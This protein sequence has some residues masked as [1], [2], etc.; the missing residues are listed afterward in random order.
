[1]LLR[2]KTFP[3]LLCLFLIAFKVAASSIFVQAA[4][5]RAEL[6]GDYSSIVAMQMNPETSDAADENGKVHTMYLMSHVTAN[7]STAE[8]AMCQ[9]QVTSIQYFVADKVLLTQ[10]F[11]D[12]EF[13]PPKVI[14]SIHLG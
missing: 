9:T 6:A 5:E 14:A 8:V 3:L 1:M 12:A 10:N 7:I 11:P 13:K 4:I 2:R